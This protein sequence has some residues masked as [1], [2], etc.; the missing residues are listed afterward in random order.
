VSA[1]PA[2]VTVPADP[3]AAAAALGLA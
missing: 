2:P 1:A 3:A